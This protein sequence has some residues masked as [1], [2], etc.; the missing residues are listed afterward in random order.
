MQ[1]LHL[2]HLRLR[3]FLVGASL[4]LVLPVCGN[5][6]LRSSMHLKGTNLNLKGHTVFSDDRSMQ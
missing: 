4:L 1:P 3:G 5:T 2:G 6:E